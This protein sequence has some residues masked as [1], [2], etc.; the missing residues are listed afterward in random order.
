[1]VCV[2]TLCHCTHADLA[3]EVD[4]LR[5]WRDSG[6]PRSSVAPLR[7]LL[8][9]P[10]YPAFAAGHPHCHADETYQ[11]E[12]RQASS[13]SMRRSTS[14]T[15][16]SRTRS[17]R[18]YFADASAA[19]EDVGEDLEPGRNGKRAAAGAGAAAAAAAERGRPSPTSTSSSRSASPSSCEICTLSEDAVESLGLEAEHGY[20]LPVDS[21][22]LG[23]VL[24]T[25][26]TGEQPFFAETDRPSICV[27]KLA[28]WYN[29]GHP[30]LME[31]SSDARDLLHRLLDPCPRARI[32]VEGALE[33]TWLAR[34]SSASSLASSSVPGRGRRR[35]HPAAPLRVDSVSGSGDGNDDEDEVDEDGV[36]VRTAH[37]DRDGPTKRRKR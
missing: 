12:V 34:R 3:P 4:M 2:C 29:G 27:Q 5:F 13:P 10:H 37:V 16:S 19:A 1:M 26:L 20:G 35:G 14:T 11:L 17:V 31:C 6:E 7:K 33:H 25:M 32:S 28:R 22:S 18:A 21:F 8:E 23:V 24:Y 15:S 36:D 9:I 30:L